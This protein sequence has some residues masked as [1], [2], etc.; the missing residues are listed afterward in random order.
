MPIDSALLG[1]QDLFNMASRA[2]ESDDLVPLLWHVLAWGAMGDLRNAP[3]VVRSAEDSVGRSRLNDILAAA[4]AASYRGD[5]QAAYRAIHRKIKRLGPAFF[6]KFLY[7]TGDRD[8]AY[9]RCMILDSR[10]AEAVITLTGNDFLDQKPSVYSQF[11]GN[12]RRWADRYG[13]EPDLIEFKLYKFGQ[14]IGSRRWRWLHA[15]A[16][17]YRAGAA[18]VG[19]DDIVREVAGAERR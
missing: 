2:R 16:C 9:P 1:R 15:E 11:C 17:L 3:T 6:S 4:A 5:I 12:I 7:F 10:V 13:E 8:S 19:F 14:L 18:S